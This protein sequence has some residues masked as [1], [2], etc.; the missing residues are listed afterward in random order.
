[1]VPVASMIV[2]K[3]VSMPVDVFCRDHANVTHDPFWIDSEFVEIIHVGG[4]TVG[5]GTTTG[6]AVTTTLQAD[7][8]VVFVTLNI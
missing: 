5:G 3:G 7:I 4:R 8:P 2:P 6:E 1:M